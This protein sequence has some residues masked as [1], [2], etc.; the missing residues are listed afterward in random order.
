MSEMAYL[1]LR[2]ESQAAFLQVPE[3]FVDDDHAQ[4]AIAFV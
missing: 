4:R 1:S 3:G 2:C